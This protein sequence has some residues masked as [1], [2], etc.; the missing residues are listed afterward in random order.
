MAISEQ[1]LR[2]ERWRT[3]LVNEGLDA[4]EAFLQEYPAAD[5]SELKRLVQSSAA[6]HR[7]HDTP[8]KLLHY[9]RDLDDTRAS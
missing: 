5:K 6:M 1:L 9:I 8:R 3:R 2:I 7:K 4:I